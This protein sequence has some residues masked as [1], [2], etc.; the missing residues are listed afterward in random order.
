MQVEE[1]GGGMSGEREELVYLSL[2]TPGQGIC[3]MGTC[4]VH[5]RA[6]K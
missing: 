5:P 4:E 3:A 2:F 1:G 6:S